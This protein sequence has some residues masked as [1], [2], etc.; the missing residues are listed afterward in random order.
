MERWDQV[1]QKSPTE[2]WVRWG[3]LNQ[4][5]GVQEE[6]GSCWKIERLLWSSYS[7]IKLKNSLTPG[8][9]CW[10]C[11][12]NYR[13]FTYPHINDI[14]TRQCQQMYQF[15]NIEHSVLLLTVNKCTCV[16]S[17]FKSII[18]LG[19]SASGVT[20]KALKKLNRS[21]QEPDSMHV[22]LCQ[23][24]FDIVWMLVEANHL[25]LIEK[26]VNRKGETKRNP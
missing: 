13:M 6:F 21:E 14:S 18:P 20:Q 5:T 1:F 2:T 9:N 15:M 23:C 4:A 11:L 3:C 24:W 8:G 19:Y 7:S 22:I 17:I 25:G 26:L 12:W 10:V 16:T